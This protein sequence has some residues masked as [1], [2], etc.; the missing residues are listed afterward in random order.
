M[1]DSRESLRRAHPCLAIHPHG[2]STI[3]GSRSL[4]F[5]N[6]QF[7]HLVQ[8]NAV[9]TYKQIK[10]KPDTIIQTNY[11]RNK[12]GLCYRASMTLTRISLWSA[13]QGNLHPFEHHEF[14]F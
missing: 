1:M 12:R 8:D 6:H 3:S 13:H 14:L 10:Y 2:D 4:V 11:S 7:Y 9:F 5:R